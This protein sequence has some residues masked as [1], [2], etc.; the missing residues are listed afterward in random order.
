MDFIREFRDKDKILALAKLVQNESKKLEKP[1]NIMEI[2]GGHTHSI[3]K[4]GVPKLCGEM[5]NFI[6]GP[7]CPVCVMP[8]ERIDEAIKLAD[9][10]NTIFC[11]LADMMRVKGSYKSLMDLR[12]SG[13]DIRALYS[14]LEAL[15]IATNNPAKRVIFFAIGFETT[16]PM[17]AVLIQKSL[18]MGV[19]NLF[20]HINHVKVP[21]A[22]SA[23]MSDKCCKIK[24]FLAPSHVSVIVGSNEYSV[25]A[26]NFKTPFAICGFEP[27]DVLDSVLNL[28]HQSLQ[29]SHEIYNE[30]K[31]AVRPNGNELAKSIVARY[32]KPCDFLWR[33]LGLIANSGMD[34]K[35]EFDEINAKKCFDCKVESLKENKACICAEILKGLAKPYDCKVFGKACTPQ[36][37]IGSCMVSGEG[38]CAAYYKY[39]RRKY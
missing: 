5:I 29:N 9:D 30:Y 14:P 28:I 19:K 31:R 11:T 38:A 26:K 12:A 2:C 24:A 13:R 15:K 34:L 25:L 36:N 1:L 3:M 32:L 39:A 8:R 37:P 7:G 6:H 17:S 33:G 21:E 16:T 4:F 35:S 27:L 18:E 10:E 22:I 20:F 23:I